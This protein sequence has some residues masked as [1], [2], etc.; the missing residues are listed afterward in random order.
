MAKGA[1][2]G[3][4]WQADW[5]VFLTN[6]HL[7]VIILPGATAGSERRTLNRYRGVAPTPIAERDRHDWGQ[8]PTCTLYYLSGPTIWT[9]GASPPR[10]T[11]EFDPAPFAESSCWATRL[12][13]KSTRLKF[14]NLLIQK[15]TKSLTQMLKKNFR[16]R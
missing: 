4:D 8:A 12:R 2:L 9:N 5:L 6:W 7:I 15:Y 11:R 13:M 3:S 14:E 10:H 16:V 1:G